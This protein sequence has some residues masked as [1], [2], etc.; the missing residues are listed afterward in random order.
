MYLNLARNC[1]IT[2]I[3]LFSY[4]NMEAC[5]MIVLGEVR[6]RKESSMTVQIDCDI[7]DELKLL[8]KKVT[9]WEK[10]IEEK[11]GQCPFWA[12]LKHFVYVSFIIAPALIL[13]LTLGLIINKND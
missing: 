8:Y 7:W 4:Q 6:I 13:L 5:I 10:K 1:A 12:W 9:E 3:F 2:E 11:L